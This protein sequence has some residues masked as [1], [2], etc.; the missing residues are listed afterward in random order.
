M[1]K[2]HH[3]IILFDLP[4]FFDNRISFLTSRFAESGH[5]T[6]ILQV[7]Y[8]ISVAPFAGA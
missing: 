4:K 6:H 3:G 5:S 8:N 2:L 1:R 7:C